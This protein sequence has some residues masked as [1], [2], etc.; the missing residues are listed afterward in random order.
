MSNTKNFILASASPQRK[1][2]LAQIGF[3]PKKI[4]TADIDET[5]KKNEAATAYVK[6][7]ALE[8]ALKVAENNSGEVVLAADTTIV[9]G[10]KIINKSQ[11]DAEQEKIMR[12][13]SGK[14]H[15]VITAVCVIGKD[16]KKSLKVNTTRILMK[17]MSEKEIKDYV[18]SKEWCGCCGYKIEGKMAY[19]VKKM[20]GSYSGVVGLPLYET[21]NLLDGAGI[22]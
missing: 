17:K 9:V 21:K 11:N 13:M 12:M 7:M 2:L 1:T 14:S 15:R 6:R 22:R 19:L 18:K 10:T 20:I 5:P 3:E 8:K 4:E 16:G